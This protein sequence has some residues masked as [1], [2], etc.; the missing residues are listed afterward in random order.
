MPEQ[1]HREKRFL[2]ITCDNICEIY[3]FALMKGLSQNPPMKS[4]RNMQFTLAKRLNLM[5]G[6][7][8]IK[9]TG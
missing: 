2:S 9:Y 8:D 6:Y 3:T 4:K 1:Q 5:D 7:V